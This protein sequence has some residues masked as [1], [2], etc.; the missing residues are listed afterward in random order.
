[1][2]IDLPG[3]VEQL[4][5]FHIGGEVFRP[6]EH[7]ENAS[8]FVSD[9]DRDFLVFRVKRRPECGQLAAKGFARSLSR[10]WRDCP[11]STS[12]DDMGILDSVANAFENLAA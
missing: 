2:R 11:A 9:A 1:M 3:F 7:I 6:F 10:F 12:E 4:E 5:F 8:R